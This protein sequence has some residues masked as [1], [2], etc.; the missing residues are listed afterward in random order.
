[1]EEFKEIK[2]SSKNFFL[3]RK[4]MNESPKKFFLF[5]ISIMYLVKKRDLIN[6]PCNDLD[7]LF[8]CF[9]KFKQD[10]DYITKVII[11]NNLMQLLYEIKQLLCERTKR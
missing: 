1:M 2:E 3:F 4:K 5:M 8:V 10:V 7:K 6:S 11:L 9:S